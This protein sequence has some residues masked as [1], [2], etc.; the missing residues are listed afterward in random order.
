MRLAQTPRGSPAPGG[1]W[2]RSIAAS[3]Q[4]PRSTLSSPTGPP[5]WYENGTASVLLYDAQCTGSISHWP[6]ALANRGLP[7]EHTTDEATF[8]SQ[9][10]S[11][12]VWDLVLVDSYN[13]GTTAAADTALAA[14]V[15]GGGRLYVDSY[16]LVDHPI[17]ANALEATPVAASWPCA[18]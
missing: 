9:L 2:R 6:T 3:R 5:T 1:R 13:S 11:G 8:L 10:G 16:N 18:S 17:L 4:P 12:V 7:F 14:Y 15:T